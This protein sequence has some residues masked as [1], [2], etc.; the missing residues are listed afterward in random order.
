MQHCRITDRKTFRAGGQQVTA[1]GS[2]P[3]LGI[4]LW[5]SLS[6]SLV[7][8]A[9][10]AGLPDNSSFERF[11]VIADKNIFARCRAADPKSDV[12]PQVQTDPGL[13]NIC[14]VGIVRTSDPYSSIAVIADG[15]RH[16]LCRIGD[17]VG[18]MIL[19][20]IRDHDIVFETPSGHWV[21]QIEPGTPA[22]HRM[23][24]PPG[25]TTPGFVAAPQES[26]PGGRK[27]LPV[28]AI[29]V[30]QLART[31]LITYREN[32]T[33]RGLE[34]TRDALG[35]KAG[36]RVTHV[37]GQALCT[38][39]PKQKLWQIVR[40]HSAS[41]ERGTEIHV[42]VERNSRTLEFLVAPIG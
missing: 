33:V 37:D 27:R 39:R 3:V 23:I 29:E 40:K 41:R 14:L 16:R 7:A 31:G 32:G 22:Q 28:R 15:G 34:L 19:R 8:S 11:R 1:P 5:A 21:A 17:S 4:L 30:E 18:S 6:L 13:P 42:V 10:L 38:R 24:S 2:A 20:S 9:T 26:A 12:V 25:P 36:D 35:L